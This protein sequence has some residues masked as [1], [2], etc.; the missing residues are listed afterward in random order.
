MWRGTSSTA[1]R[2]HGSRSNHVCFVLSSCQRLL[3]GCDCLRSSRQCN[4]GSAGCVVDVGCK[5][6]AAGP[7]LLS[8]EPAIVA[9]PETPGPSMTT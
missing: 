5:E 6:N 7:A 1:S 8:F 9:T 3:G 4:L 2:K